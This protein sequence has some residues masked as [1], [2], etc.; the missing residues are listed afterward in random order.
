MQSRAES[1]HWFTGSRF[2]DFP[3]ASNDWS[4]GLITTQHPIYGSLAQQ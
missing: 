1:G 4:L 3:P 2:F